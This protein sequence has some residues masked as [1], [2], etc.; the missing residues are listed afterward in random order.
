M[1][2]DLNKDHSITVI[3]VYHEEKLLNK[4]SD[5]VIHLQDGKIVRQEDTL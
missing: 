1:L 3:M 5:K 4:Y 2:A